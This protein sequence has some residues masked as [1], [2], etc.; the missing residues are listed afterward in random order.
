MVGLNTGLLIA[1]FDRPVKVRGYSP[2][3]GERT[4]KT[5]S[6]VVPYTHSDGIVYMLIINQA[7]LITYIEANLF[8]DI[9]ANLLCPM[10]L[11][12][13][14]IKVND[15]PKS[16]LEHPTEWNHCIIVEDLK[17]SLSLKGLFHISQSQS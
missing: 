2:S 15:E 14:E 1:N 11:R 16:M 5:V 12:D 9:E 3:V 7:V 4:C 17:I 8:T 10:Q 6:A 13:N